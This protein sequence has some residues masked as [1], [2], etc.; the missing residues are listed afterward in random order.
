[1]TPFC[2][3]IEQMVLINDLINERF[4]LWAVRIGY[5]AS[6]VPHVANLSEIL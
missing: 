3:F 2:N 1:M 5:F 6:M 4:N